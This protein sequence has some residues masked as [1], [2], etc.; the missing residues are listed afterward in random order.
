[1]PDVAKRYLWLLDELGIERAAIVGTSLGGW[2]AAELATMA[3]ERCTS[4]TVV[5]PFGV[6]TEGADVFDIFMTVY[7]DYMATAFTDH[8]APGYREL[9]VD[10]GADLDQAIQLMELSALLGFRPYMHDAHLRQFLARVKAPALVAWAEDDRVL[11]R[12]AAE[13]F[14]AS[15]PS[16][17][18][19]VLPAGGHFPLIQ[20]PGASIAAIKRHLGKGR[21]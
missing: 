21:G 18:L 11:P 14:A 12:E 13:A 19:V 5:S 8:G 15:L 9:Y 7:G 6:R 4:L 3:P 16:S 2:I 10:D 17:E 1:V 20:E